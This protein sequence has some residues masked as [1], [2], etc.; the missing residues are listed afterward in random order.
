MCSRKFWFRFLWIPGH[1]QVAG[2]HL[3]GEGLH[4]PEG[5][6]ASSRV[7]KVDFK[8]TDAGSAR[9]FLPCPASLLLALWASIPLFHV[10]YPFC[11]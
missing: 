8:R 6:A 7:S 9:P 2:A 11:K 4:F 5:N 1:T 3:E 10:Q